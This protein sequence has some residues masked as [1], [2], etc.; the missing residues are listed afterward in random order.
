MLLSFWGNSNKKMS[1]PTEKRLIK[2]IQSYMLREDLGDEF[3]GFKV[4][5]SIRSPVYLMQQ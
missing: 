1:C 4:A 5:L 3:S 2:V